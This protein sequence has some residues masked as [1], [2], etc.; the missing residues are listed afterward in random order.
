MF[1]WL[2][3]SKSPR[4]IDGGPVT[5]ISRAVSMGRRNTSRKS[6]VLESQGLRVVHEHKSKEKASCLGK[7]ELQPRRIVP[8]E[9][10]CQVK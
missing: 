3:T 8:L 7:S 5:P 10:Y 6:Q 4:R 2:T 9:T 1:L